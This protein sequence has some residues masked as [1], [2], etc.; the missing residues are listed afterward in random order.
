M[1]SLVRVG[2]GLADREPLFM[3]IRADWYLAKNSGGQVTGPDGAVVSS[4]FFYGLIHAKLIVLSF[5]HRVEMLGV[6]EV[7][8]REV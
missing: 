1:T 7:G 5:V 2:A 8:A 3:M 4:D 6:G